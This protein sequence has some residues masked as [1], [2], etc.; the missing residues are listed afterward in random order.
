MNEIFHPDIAHIESYPS[1]TDA[2]RAA[3]LYISN[4][5]R[6]N[7]TAAVTFATGETMKPVLRFLG[8]AVRDHGVTLVQIVARHLD[9]YWPCSTSDEHSFVKYLRERVWLL[10]VNPKNI[11][12]INGEAEDPNAEAE[13]YETLLQERPSDLVILGIG[14]WDIETQTG[15]HIGFNEAG[16][17]FDHGTH[18]A[19]LHAST[20]RRDREERGQSTPD[21]A[22]TQGVAN[23]LAAR[24]IMLVAYGEN[25]GVALG[26]ALYD[27]ISTQRPASAL[28]K[29]G[30]RVTIFLDQA[31]SSTMVQIEGQLTDMLV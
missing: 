1:V 15:G 19:T 27:P 4:F 29:V 7:P 12:E 8:E 11:Y 10:G 26:H 31:A 14:P 17:P 13:R 21:Y 18:L 28:R 24:E 2:A 20:T 6:I 16:T 23:I 22:I 9:E 25:K 5:V 30:E 3:S